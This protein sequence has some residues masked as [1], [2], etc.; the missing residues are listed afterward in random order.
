MAH[1]LTG[2][3]PRHKGATAARRACRACRMCTGPGQTA[4]PVVR[5]HAQPARTACIPRVW[6]H[7][8]G[9]VLQAPSGGAKQRLPFLP[10]LAARCNAHRCAAAL[11]II[12]ANGCRQPPTRR[13]SPFR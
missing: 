13:R 3:F 2:A 1:G 8:T 6:H 12:R 10:L 4:L 9:G 7:A 5:S 11:V